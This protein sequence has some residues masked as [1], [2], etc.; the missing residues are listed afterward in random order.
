M[1]I[2]R[3]ILASLMAT[4]I[5]LWLWHYF[6]PWQP[7][8]EWIAFT[9]SQGV[10]RGALYR[11]RPDGTDL[12]KLID[13][14]TNVRGPITWSPDGEWLAYSDP[15]HVFIMR[16]DGSE[17]RQLVSGLWPAWSPDGKR[18]AYAAGGIYVIDVNGQNSR[19]LTSQQQNELH[20]SPTWVNETEIVYVVSRTDGYYFTGVDVDTNSI[21]QITNEALR[22]SRGPVPR[23]SSDGEFVVFSIIKNE[24]G[25]TNIVKMK[26][27]SDEYKVL[28]GDM[29]G[30]Q[31]SPSWSPDGQ[32]IVFISSLGSD[33]SLYKM[34]RDGNNGQR[35][36]DDLPCS[37][38]FPV[39]SSDPS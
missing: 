27:D 3:M 15:L 4:G 36:T 9:C 38:G 39:W 20:L 11:I 1:K 22:N 24:F 6:R 16:P 33:S 12:D 34:D 14:Y 17:R 37:P 23:W 35:L 2:W 21:Q 13:F 10:Y 32:W 26:S 5:M 8:G 28:T 30:N 7:D 25:E 18:I 31:H 29:S 19:K